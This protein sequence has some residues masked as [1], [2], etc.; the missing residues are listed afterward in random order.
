[1]FSNACSDSTYAGHHLLCSLMTTTLAKSRN[2]T[3]WAHPHPPP[4]N[5]PPLRL[6]TNPPMWTLWRWRF[7]LDLPQT[8]E[9]AGKPRLRP[10]RQ[11]A[12]K[13]YR[14]W[15]FSLFYLYFYFIYAWSMRMKMIT[16]DALE[17]H[18]GLR[19]LDRATDHAHS[20]LKLSWC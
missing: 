11:H 14:S 1:M 16:D 7:W 3:E 15:G 19:L 18:S 20:L 8:T 17:V 4:E 6:S 10:P 9:E 5:R 13:G 12:T 2:Q